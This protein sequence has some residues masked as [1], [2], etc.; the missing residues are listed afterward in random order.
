MTADEYTNET[1]FLPVGN[2][3]EI[4]VHDWGNKEANTIFFFLHGGP[5]GLCKDKHK[6]AFDPKTQRV[7]FHDQRGSGQSLPLGELEHNTTQELSGDIT[8]IAEY[9]KVNKFVI[10]GS[11]WGST[12]SLYYAINNPNHVSAIVVGGVWGASQEEDEYMALGSWRTHFPD[13]WDWYASTVPKQ[14]EDNPTAY[15]FKQSSGK[16]P[17]K[18]A[19]SARAFNDM[20]A[21]LMSLDDQHLKTPETGYDPS[22]NLIEMHYMS[23]N[24]FFP[25]RYIIDNASKI[26]APLHI[27]QGRYDFVCPPSTAYELHCAIPGSTLT[28]I[29]SGH[30]SEHETTTAF[31][32]IYRQLTK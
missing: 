6:L 7:I 13:L 30:T 3:Y 18:A 32:L 28:W 22:G 17:E 27:I 21:G 26:T 8:K 19:R 25:D 20:E 4:W 11:S 1:F 12:L 14:Y 24:C 2:G 15:H 9:L 16:D 31:K 5:D 29:T 10:T 23:K